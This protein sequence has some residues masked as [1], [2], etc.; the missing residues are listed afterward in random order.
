MT[1][2]MRSSELAALYGRQREAMV[3]LARLLTGSAG[4]AEEIVQESFLKMHQLEREPEN[5]DAYLRVIVANLSKSHLRRL[6]LERRSSPQERIILDEP[7]FDETWAAVC[8][9]PFRLRAVLVLRFYQDLSES[10]ISRVLR[11]KPGT[12]KS[13]LHR[14]LTKLREELK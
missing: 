9:L 6:R 8:R 2:P 14:G 3:R 1:S 4:V 12:V 5:P 13:R 7:A 10:E 11:C